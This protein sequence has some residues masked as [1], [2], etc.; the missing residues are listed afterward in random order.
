MCDHG[1]L[2]R[3]AVLGA[4]VAA[5]AGAVLAGC[6]ATDRG[7]AAPPSA[8][9][10]PLPTGESTASAPP[11]T[12][13]PTATAFDRSAHSVDDPRSIWVVVDKRRPLQPQS[14]VPPDLVTP[15]VPHTN[16]P[17][18]RRA[19]ARALERMFADAGTDGIT[20]VSLS[21]FRSFAT[22]RAI[23]DRNVEQLGLTTTLGLSAKAGFS[24]HQT[25]LADDIGDGGPADLSVAFEKRPAAGWLT[26]T[27]WRYG[28]VQRY[29]PGLTAITGIQVEPWHFRY[30]GKPAAREMHRTRT[31][32]LEQFFDLPPSPDYS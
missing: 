11:P 30:I 13:G 3:R 1:P 27:S 32:T 31:R 5:G 28:F 7:R 19:A 25:G 8:G 18:L 17:R 20:L 23:F 9:P 2:T 16:P 29:P 12:S 10:A 26:A 6:S 21:A 22:Q 14:W 24:E 15:D 4:A